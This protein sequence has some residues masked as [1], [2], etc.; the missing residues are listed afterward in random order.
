MLN[1]LS[2]SIAKYLKTQ[3]CC[4]LDL[5]KLN[6]TCILSVSNPI[7]APQMLS[8]LGFCYHDPVLSVCSYSTLTSD[9]SFSPFLAA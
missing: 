1:N 6:H 8:C 9:E 4:E 3:P 7:P 2:S 5:D